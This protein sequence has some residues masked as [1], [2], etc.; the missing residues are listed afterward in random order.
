MFLVFPQIY[1]YG[2]YS[3][4]AID[5]PERFALTDPVWEIVDL[6]DYRRRYAQYHMDEGLQNLRARAPQLSVRC[7]RV[8]CFETT[9]MGSYCCF[10]RIR[11]D[12]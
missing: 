3:T 2:T 5:S 6:N 1:E 4:Y 11:I 9:N 12:L 8:A 7:C 10:S